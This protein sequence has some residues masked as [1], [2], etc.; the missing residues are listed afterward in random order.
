MK[1]T[2]LLYW[3]NPVYLWCTYKRQ[4]SCSIV[5][6]LIMFTLFYPPFSRLPGAHQMEPQ[7]PLI[8]WVNPFPSRFINRR[9]CFQ[10]K[11]HISVGLVCHREKNIKLDEVE[12]RS[13]SFDRF[14]F[15]YTSIFM[16]LQPLGSGYHE[17]K[18]NELPDWDWARS[19][20]DKERNRQLLHASTPYSRA[21]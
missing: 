8:S 13:P 10:R 17:I 14:P 2:Y 12:L 7:S 5:P 15:Y 18:V 20:W 21:T 9:A 1:F 16:I 19:G 11:V 3:Y 4:C 6:R